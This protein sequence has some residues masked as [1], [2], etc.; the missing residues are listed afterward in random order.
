MQIYHYDPTTLLLLAIGQADPSPLEE[1][2]FLIPAH[3]TEVA[4]PDFDP[5]S[6]FCRFVDGGWVLAEIPQ[7]EP[8]PPP[9]PPTTAQLVA[10]QLAAI[11][12]DCEAAIAKITAGYPSSEVLSW[13]KQEAEARAYIADNAAA[14]PLLDALAE[15]RGVAKAELASRIIAK[16][17]AFSTL[18][19]SLIGKRQALEDALMALP[20]DATVEQVVA[21]VWTP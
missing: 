6:H 7:P 11:N 21:I 20:T 19:G 17:D 5:S 4:P 2:V 9:E 8:E 14:T 10:T 13:P 16:A 12:S 1:G 15:A 18:S 3:A